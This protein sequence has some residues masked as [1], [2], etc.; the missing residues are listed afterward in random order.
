M[1]N[2]L[3]VLHVIPSVSALRGGPS[4]AVIEMVT[5][6]RQ[7]GVLAEIATTNDNAVGTLQVPIGELQT[8][9]GVPVRF[10]KRLSPPLSAA[11][12][13]SFSFG[14][15]NWLRKHISDYDVIHVH[16][17]FSFVSTFAMFLARKKGIPYIVRPIGQLEEWSLQQSSNR[18]AVYLRLIEHKNLLG[19]S[20]IHFTAES[21][22]QQA[23]RVIPELQSC[24]IPLGLSIPM[25][26]SQARRKMRDRWHLERG[27]PTI[28]YLSRLHP[29]KGLDLL[30]DALAIVDDFPFQLLIAGE[31]D[32]VFKKALQDKILR[33]ELDHCC[34]FLGFV[35]GSQKNLLLQGAD[36]YVLT[37][38]SENFGIA[39]LE[40]MAS[41]T[42]V[43]VS[44]Q[45]ALSKEVEKHK[46]GFVT[47]LDAND[48]RREL[49]DALADIDATRELGDAAHDY[50]EQHY[51]WSSIASRL[52]KLY[53]S[54]TS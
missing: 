24:V 16:A 10:F 45:V 31:G 19:A 33:L 32:K 21:E 20:S 38:H 23:L 5:A 48:I 9:Q 26:I 18:K 12:E 39:V 22:Q 17:I 36:L 43:L 37:S 11:R 34:K 54:I 50:A 52:I 35:Q 4:K 15:A 1:S 25:P 6:L 41:G 49:I 14:F 2:N 3:K 44:Q 40:A 27:T 42:A 47:A 7:S 28:L 29:K 30:L 51:Q 8:H 53:K 46:L 13:F